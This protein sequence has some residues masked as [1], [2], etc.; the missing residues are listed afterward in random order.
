MTTIN[1]DRQLLRDFK[2][3]RRRL[4]KGNKLTT[5]IR[6]RDWLY[7][8][9]D[10]KRIYKEALDNLEFP[11]TYGMTYEGAIAIVI[12]TYVFLM[13]IAWWGGGR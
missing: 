8:N 2:R 1:E 10:Q 7:F 11:R 9:K 5:F 4:R 6:T 3:L 12:V 13:L